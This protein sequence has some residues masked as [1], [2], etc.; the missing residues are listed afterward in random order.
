VL[1]SENRE[2]LVV[3]LV[4]AIHLARGGVK[5]GKRG[6]SDKALGQQ[7]FLA[8]VKCALERA[9]LPAKRWRKQY[10]NDGGES[11]YFRL[12]REVGEAADILLPVDL[13]LLAKQAAQIQYGVMPPTMEAAQN[14]ELAARRR[15]QE[16]QVWGG[17]LVDPPRTCEELASAYLGFPF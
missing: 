13:K 9:G 15:Q 5:A 8:D 17:H 16:F 10:D 12:A 14:A 3:D 4:R 11:L 6:V 2:Q 1:S 7:V